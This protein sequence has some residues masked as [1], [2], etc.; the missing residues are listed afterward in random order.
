[1]RPENKSQSASWPV[2]SNSMHVKLRCLIEDV[3]GIWI[4]KEV[5]ITCFAAATSQTGT[6]AVQVCV[7]HVLPACLQF[8]FATGM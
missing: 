6:E 3:D 7:M 8:T 1:M 5:W 4:T 2:T